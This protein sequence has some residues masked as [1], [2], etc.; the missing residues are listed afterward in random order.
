MD[1]YHLIYTST[2]AYPIV[3]SGM[4]EILK[5]AREH[6]SRFQV[7]G[8]LICLPYS[9]VQLIEGPKEQIQQLYKNI[10]RDPRHLKVTI[11]REGPI[12]A[13]YFPNWTMAFTRRNES[14][15]NADVLHV[16]EQQVLRLLDILEK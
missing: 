13:R 1:L 2:P 14:I 7:T 11:L 15:N 3:D 10:Q 4:E 12:T 16:F 8:M 9:F 5:T 6:N